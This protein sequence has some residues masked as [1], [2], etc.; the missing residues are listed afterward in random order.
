VD[1]RTADLQNPAGSIT[2]GK[3][4][5]LVVLDRDILSMKPAEM[6][7]HVFMTVLGGQMVYPK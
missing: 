3:L 2:P 6:A 5:E 1:R 7:V 4:M